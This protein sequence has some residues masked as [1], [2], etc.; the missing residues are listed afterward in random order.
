MKNSTEI[1]E[2]EIWLRLI[3]RETGDLSPESAREWLRLR[4][5]N[6]DI[7]RIRD[8]SRKA[9]DGVLTPQS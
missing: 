5:S 1:S 4:F 6:I 2:I 9:N 3:L 8:L 7:E